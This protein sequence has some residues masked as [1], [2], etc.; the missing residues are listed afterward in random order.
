[1]K[2]Q[3]K[4]AGR[5]GNI[6]DIARLDFHNWYGDL[7][8]RT[9]CCVNEK[10]QGFM[11]L[12]KIKNRFSLSQSDIEHFREELKERER[13][14]FEGMEIQAKQRIK[15]LGP[16]EWT[17]DTRGQIITPWSKKKEED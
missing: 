1:M 14:D 4:F 7:V 17:R 2:K 10:H 9:K 5:S 8:D 6:S 13:I 11:M 12:E 15:G 16:V 3:R